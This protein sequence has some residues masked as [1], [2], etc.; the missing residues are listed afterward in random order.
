MKIYAITTDYES[1]YAYYSNKATAEWDL[2]NKREFNS[3]YDYIIEIE[4][5]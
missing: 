2:A 5:N 4:V 1:P 3:D